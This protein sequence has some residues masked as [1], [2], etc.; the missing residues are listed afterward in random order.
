MHIP[1]TSDREARQRLAAAVTGGDALD[2]DPDQDPDAEFSASCTLDPGDLELFAIN[3]KP[4]GDDIP[5][6]WDPDR[7]P[8]G[9]MLPPGVTVDRYTVT[10]PP[11]DHPLKATPRVHIEPYRDFFRHDVSDALLIRKGFPND[12]LVW[13]YALGDW[14]YPEG[15]DPAHLARPLQEVV[16]KARALVGLD[17]RTGFPP[18][19]PT[20]GQG[21]TP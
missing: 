2:L 5:V 12:R 1:A 15:P 6:T 19:A 4:I 21:D 14:A 11:R 10:C 17:P 9:A 18:T 3:G 16:R 8:A 7:A 13:N 20:A